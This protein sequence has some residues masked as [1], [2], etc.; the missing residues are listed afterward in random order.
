MKTLTEEQRT[1]WAT[2]GYIHLESALSQEEVAFFSDKL[3][4]V[5]QLPGYEP[6]PDELQRGHYKWLDHADDL[7]PEGFMDRRDLLTYDQAFID[8]VDKPDVFDLIVDI[9]GPWIL[10]SMSQ[11]IVRAATNTFPGYTHTDGG[12]AL[13]RIRVSET[14]R[15]LAMKAMYLLSDVE[16]TDSGN[17]TV[18]PGSHLRPFPEDNIELT[19]HTPGAAQLTGK[20]GD[21]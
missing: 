5:R 9:M 4:E 7:D 11:A 17:F 14:R 10:F 12:E 8:L 3:D 19:P 18:F 1:K 15:P 6:R 13:R 2:D 21:A 20:A 16:G